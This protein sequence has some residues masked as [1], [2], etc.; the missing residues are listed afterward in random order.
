MVGNE[1][2]RRYRSDGT[3]GAPRRE[4]AHTFGCAEPPGQR[5]G[6]P[7]RTAM[8]DPGPHRPAVPLGPLMAGYRGLTGLPLGVGTL[9]PDVSGNFDEPSA[10]Q[11]GH[12]RAGCVKTL[13][14]GWHH[15]CWGGCHP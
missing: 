1:P 8:S 15:G 9:G 10:A 13:T 2:G 5:G 4:P 7:G 14:G 11:L 6:K 12:A 3:V